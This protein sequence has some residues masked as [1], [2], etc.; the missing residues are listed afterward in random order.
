MK[1][2]STPKVRERIVELERMARSN[3]DLSNLAIKVSNV[4]AAPNGFMADVTINEVLIPD[5]EYPRVYFKDCVLK[6]MDE[7]DDPNVSG[8]FYRYD[9]IMSKLERS[10]M[11]EEGVFLN[12]VKVF[13]IKMVNSYTT[14]KRTLSTKLD[15]TERNKAIAS[16]IKCM[17]DAESF[18]NYI[19]S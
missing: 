17:D 10:E 2:Y 15:I 19:L 7:A 18:L 16:L 13:I 11:Y 6:E 1:S 12:N 4:R 8:I 3:M 9:G 5:V 14:L